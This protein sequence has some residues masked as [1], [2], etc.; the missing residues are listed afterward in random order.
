MAQEVQVKE[1]FSCKDDMPIG[2][3]GQPMQPPMGS[4][5]GHVAPI[6]YGNPNQHH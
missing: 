5:Q 6:P 1:P 2:P 3:D 4:A